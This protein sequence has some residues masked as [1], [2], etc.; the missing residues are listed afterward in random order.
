MSWHLQEPWRTHIISLW[1]L[2]ACNMSDIL[3]TVAYSIHPFS[4]NPAHRGSPRSNCVAI[5]PLSGSRSIVGPSSIASPSE[6]GDSTSISG[7][8]WRRLLLL[9]TGAGAGIT[10]RGL[11]VVEMGG[12]GA[13]AAEGVG[14][15]SALGAGLLEASSTTPWTFC[16]DAAGGSIRGGPRNGRFFHSVSS[17]L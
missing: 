17:R 3:S 10:V 11:A 2:M 6:S 15:T 9:A 4:P 14:F 7:D 16:G 1:L 12:G 8:S 13:G 5:S